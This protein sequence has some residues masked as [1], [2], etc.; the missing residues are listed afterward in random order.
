MASKMDRE[1]LIGMALT[2]G[3][4]FRERLLHMPEEVARE[5]GI[6]LSAREIE[7]IKKMDPKA[8]EELVE[9]FQTVTGELTSEESWGS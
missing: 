4:A 7:L 6:V 2:R 5:V 9:R 3:A 1:R 8:V